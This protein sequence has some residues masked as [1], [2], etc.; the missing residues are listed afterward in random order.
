M[1]TLS[2]YS[3]HSIQFHPS[4]K[5]SLEI[6]IEPNDR[7]PI[8]EEGVTIPILPTC[9]FL[10]FFLFPSNSVNLFFLWQYQPNVPRIP[11]YTAAIE[12]RRIRP[13]QIRRVSWFSYVKVLRFPKT[14]SSRS[15]RRRIENAKLLEAG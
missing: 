6:W 8:G 13:N 9:L 2:S 3:E 15:S 12:I 1:E 11:V 10:S 7:I 5:H 14:C 4:L